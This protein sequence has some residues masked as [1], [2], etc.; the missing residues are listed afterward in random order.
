MYT[1][2]TISGLPGA[3]ST[4]LLV[5]LKEALKNDGWQGFSG[6][7]FMR[8]YATEHG[9]F[10]PSTGGHHDASVYSDDFDRA[11]DMGMRQKLQD[12]SKWILESWLSGFL[13][14]QVPSVLKV[15]MIC[16]NKAVRIDRI[17]NRD[18][19][20]PDV[21]LGNMNARYEKNLA[22]WQRLYGPEWHEWVVSQNK[23]KSTDPIDFWRQDLYDVVID[24]YSVS[25]LEAAEIVLNAIKSET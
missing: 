13:A 22:K 5:H 7:E 19:I 14:Q 11:V 8:A 16:S 23:A 4:T 12:E 1:N 9:L 3:G 17:V 24:T 25:Q 10:D 18:A 2:I 6:G 20:S 21:A 15:L